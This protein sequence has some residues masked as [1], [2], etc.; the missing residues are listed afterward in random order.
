MLN[1]QLDMAAL[2][3]R[4]ANAMAAEVLR[5]EKMALFAEQQ[6]FVT[7]TRHAK[8]LNEAKAKAAAASDLL[9]YEVS[10]QVSA[11]MK[12]EAKAKIYSRL[13]DAS[14]RRELLVQWRLAR[15]DSRSALR[16]HLLAIDMQVLRC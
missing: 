15:L 11:K 9:D 3:Q 4:D 1:A 13:S 8:Q 7:T 2:R 10:Q 12:F 6:K 16:E 14:A 5:T